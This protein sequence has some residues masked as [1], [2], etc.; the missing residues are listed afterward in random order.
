MAF[1]PSAGDLTILGSSGTISNVIDGGGRSLAG[2]IFPASGWDGTVF[3]LKEGLGTT[4]AAGMLMYDSSA[5]A[6][7]V[8]TPASA[9]TAIMVKLKPQNYHTMQFTHLVAATAQSSAIIVKPVW[10]RYNPR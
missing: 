2:L 9:S 4:T 8:T 3:T 5:G 10:T 1:G 6:L 7:T